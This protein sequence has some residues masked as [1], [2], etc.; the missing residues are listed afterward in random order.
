ML[1]AGGFPEPE[2][3]HYKPKDFDFGKKK[4]FP[5]RDQVSLIFEGACFGSWPNFPLHMV[6]FLMKGCWTIS[7][8]FFASVEKAKTELG[9]EPKYGLVDGLAH[10]FR[11]DFGRGTF[12][13][14]ADF[15]TDD[16]ILE[17]VGTKVP[18]AAAYFGQAAP[19]GSRVG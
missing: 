3:V 9:W 11:L 4:S 18:A 10:S 8:H 1:Q 17:K 12:R 7:Q 5:L 15:S 6:P 13:K 19:A 14:A 2:L 16:Q